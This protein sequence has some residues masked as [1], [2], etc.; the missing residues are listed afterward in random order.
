MIDSLSVPSISLVNLDC[1]PKH[2]L[3]LFCNNVGLLSVC[4]LVVSLP[5]LNKCSFRM[6]QR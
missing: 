4:I 1:A 5:F 6:Y 2:F 3:Y